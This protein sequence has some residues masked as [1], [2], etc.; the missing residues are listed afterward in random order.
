VVGVAAPI[1]VSFGVEPE[2]RVAAQ[3]AVQPDWQHVSSADLDRLKTQFG[4]DWVVLERP[5]SVTLECPYQ[6]E[7][8]EVCRID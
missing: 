7:R 1:S 2:D 6:N 3:K 4:V 5:L 8:L